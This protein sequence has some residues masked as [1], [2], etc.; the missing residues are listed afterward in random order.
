MDSK[1][2]RKTDGA[3]CAEPEGSA[4]PIS[5]AA[6]PDLEGQR[7]DRAA[8]ERLS[9]AIAR[10][11]DDAA[12]IVARTIEFA[13]H[14]APRIVQQAVQQA[15]SQAARILAAAKSTGAFGTRAVISLVAAV[16]LRKILGAGRPAS[17]GEQAEPA[18]A[19]ELGL[20][21]SAPDSAA[22][23]EGSS[24]N[25]SLLGQDGADILDGDQ[26]NDLPEGGDGVD[27]LQSSAPNATAVPCMNFGS[28]SET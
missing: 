6:S 19:A 25:E 4:L 3:P 23:L 13:P 18:A 20:G 8:L 7:H 2:S 16:A 10:H 11:P 14:L 15:P 27:I 22:T 21:T 26:D 12:A 9:D 5:R 24:D 28:G 1:A 17:A